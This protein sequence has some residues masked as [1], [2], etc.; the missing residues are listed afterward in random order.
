M[1]HHTFGQVAVS[2]CSDA[3]LKEQF[4]E[5]ERQCSG[6]FRT[7]FLPMTNQR[8]KFFQSFASRNKLSR[9]LLWLKLG[10]NVGNHHTGIYYKE[11]YIQ[12]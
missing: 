4:E 8:L 2:L 6:L 1:K 7:C 10:I 12:Q 9:S 3:C 5:L 11:Y